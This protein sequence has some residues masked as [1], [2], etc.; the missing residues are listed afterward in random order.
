MRSRV[1]PAVAALLAVAA[2]SG[3]YG[4]EKRKTA[5]EFRKQIP[6]GPKILHALNRLTY[7]PRP[8]DPAEVKKVGL[9]KWIDRQ[10]RPEQIDENPL[11]LEKLKYMDT[12]RM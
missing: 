9:K 4:A 7:G 2:F 12:L 10:L 11:L 3:L 6:D 5:G 8:S 1:M